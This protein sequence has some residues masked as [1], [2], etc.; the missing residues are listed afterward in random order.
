MKDGGYSPGFA[1]GGTAAFCA[2]RGIS[3]TTLGVGVTQ[4]TFGN[5]TSNTATSFPGG[6]VSATT[7]FKAPML[8]ASSNIGPC[9]GQN[10][11]GYLCQPASNQLAAGTGTQ[12]ATLVDGNQNFQVY[13][14]LTSQYVSGNSVYPAI[15]VTCTG[16]TFPTDDSG[17]ALAGVIVTA[18][19]PV[20]TN[21]GTNG[22]I[23][24]GT[25]YLSGTIPTGTGIAA[26]TPYYVIN[27]SGS[28]A[29][30]ATSFELSATSGGTAIT[31]TSGTTGNATVVT[32]ISGVYQHSGGMFAGWFTLPTSATYGTGSYAMTLSWTNNSST[33]NPQGYKCLG[34]DESGS[35]AQLVQTSH[36]SKTAV[37]TKSTAASS[38]DVMGYQ[39][40]GTG[41]P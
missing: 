7:S 33:V 9:A 15:S 28:C 39:C 41:G 5:A 8:I 16:C 12:L 36:G 26:N 31:P 2:T 23:V 30:T 40:V 17:T 6:A 37:L 24:G 10:G 32:K 25:V 27:C 34:G 1:S 11:Q 19:N 21:T 38:G 22:L 4:L 3:G 18:N 35:G 14:M 20:F 13:Q 29:P